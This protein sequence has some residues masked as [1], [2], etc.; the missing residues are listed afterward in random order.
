MTSI[1]PEYRH[2]DFKAPPLA[3]APAATLAPAPMDGVAPKNFHATSNHPEYVRATYDLDRDDG[4]NT[5]EVAV[6]IR[7]LRDRLETMGADPS[8]VS[9][10]SDMTAD[11]Y[12]ANRTPL[13]AGFVTESLDGKPVAPLMG[14]WT[15]HDVG[16][17]RITMF[18]NFWC[19]ASS[20]HAVRCNPRAA[21]GVGAS[22]L[23]RLRLP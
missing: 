11:W 16:T 21:R 4:R 23:M 5:D 12:R 1:L 7:A 9:D 13:R 10:S 22:A 20:D 6:Q 18:P 2:P 19:H 14:K 3:D 15:D 8:T 17:A